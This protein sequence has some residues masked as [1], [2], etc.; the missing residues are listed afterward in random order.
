MEEAGRKGA[1]ILL[2]NAAEVL[3]SMDLMPE[4]VRWFRNRVP[5]HHAK[6]V[7]EVQRDWWTKLTRKSTDEEV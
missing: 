2:F 6:Q 5:Q 3:P 4:S 7:R 1:F